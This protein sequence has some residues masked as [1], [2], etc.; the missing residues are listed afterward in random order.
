M[1]ALTHGK[2]KYR[3]LYSKFIFNNIIIAIL[4]CC[5]FVFLYYELRSHFYQEKKLATQHIVESA[6]SLIS[7]YKTL[8][9]TGELSTLQAQEAAQKAIRDIRY[10][11]DNYFWINDLYPRMIMHPIKPALD[12]KSLRESK[13]PNGV[14]LFNEMVKVVKEHGKGFVEYSWAKPGDETALPKI[15]YVVLIPEWN[16]VVGSGIWVDDL[17]ASATKFF[18]ALFIALAAILCISTLAVFVIAKSILG[19][20]KQIVGQIEGGASQITPG[21]QQVSLASNSLAQSASEQSS[22]AAENAQSLKNIYELSSQNSSLAQEVSDMMSKNLL[23]A[24]RC[25]QDFEDVGKSLDNVEH[26]SD[27]I[28]KVVSTING[29]AFQTNLLALNASVEAARAGSAG[30]GFAVVAD[31]VR[32]L[33]ARVSD[34]AR[35]TQTLLTTNLGRIS[36]SIEAIKTVSSNME[37]M[38]KTFSYIGGKTK[39]ISESTNS[40]ANFLRDITNNSQQTD[41][42]IQMVA[43]IAQES[44][45]AAEQLSAH[46]HFIKHSV[47]HLSKIIEGGTVQEE[48]YS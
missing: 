31:E 16:W 6:A 2:L 21:S 11:N 23:Y 36:Q 3:S 4:F 13:D 15:S 8:S 18:M 32:A 1:N 25:L 40:Q 44:S 48:A 39:T 43:A 33:A 22:L 5:V 41:T 20:I 30:V 46:A 14:A 7:H 10:E 35:S 9:D 29:I 37:D 38:T 24:Q 47:T 17:E 19:P 27:E 26:D 28:S 42:A 34:A 45:V 12:G